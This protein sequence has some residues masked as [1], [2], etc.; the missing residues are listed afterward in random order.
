M[1]VPL[2]MESGVSVNDGIIVEISAFENSAIA[3]LT[4]II[5]S[6]TYFEGHG[7]V[8]VIASSTP[9]SKISI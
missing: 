9:I 2:F 7:V 3:F 8:V 6:E 5:W 1:L 4:D